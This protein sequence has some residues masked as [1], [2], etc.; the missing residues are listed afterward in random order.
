MKADANTAPVRGRIDEIGRLVSADPALR[1]LQQRCGGLD[2]G[3]VAIPQL[4]TIA[5]LARRLGIVVSR[6][7]VVADGD[8][9]LEL[10]VRAEPDGDEVSLAIAD[11]IPR[12]ARLPARATEV[13]R[14]HDFLRA[15]ADWLWEADDALRLTA[16]SGNAAAAIG[17][18]AAALVGAPITRLF[19]FIEAESGA[20]PILESLT[21]R[22][23]FDDQLA[24]VRDAPNLRYRLAGVPVLDDAGTFL[25]FRGTAAIAPETVEL[26]PQAPH[27]PNNAPGFGDRLERALREPL[28]RIIAGAERIRAE[29]DGPLKNEY[30]GYA[31][32]IATAARHLLAM[33]DDLVDLS[34]IESPEFQPA[35]EDVDLVEMAGA[36]AGL[37]G[38]RAIAHKITIERPGTGEKAPAKGDYRR[39]LQ[40]LVNLIGNALRYAPERSAVVLTVERSQ[41]R[42]ALTVADQGKGIASED[43]E[44][45]FERFERVDPGEAG[46]AGLGLYIAR[47]LARAMGGD[48]T[49]A[50]APGEGARFTLRLPSA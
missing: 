39:V 41:G 24:F 35:V 37:L 28:D 33:V 2:K 29:D 36:A 34:A 45:I 3:P 21:E 27:L 22:R 12:P 43:H 47:R 4:A 44:R 19:H 38:V 23:R 15:N 16:L 26:L 50:S 31:G 32:D 18:V 10:W 20:L 6:G 46:G 13:A 5:R 30:A 40:I 49:V 9:D 48:I 17:E 1:L 25:G 11:W 14:E 8:D 7:L 42:T